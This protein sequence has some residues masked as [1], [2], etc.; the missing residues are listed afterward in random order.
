[1]DK[2][3]LIGGN[4]RPDIKCL[5]DRFGNGLAKKGLMPQKLRVQKNR[6]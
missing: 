6:R 4:G 2:A 3:F 5:R 1:M